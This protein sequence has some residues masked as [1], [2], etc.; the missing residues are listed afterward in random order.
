M[1]KHPEKPG[2]SSGNGTTVSGGAVLLRAIWILSLSIILSLILTIAFSL[3]ID[4]LFGWHYIKDTM[5]FDAVPAGAVVAFVVIAYILAKVMKFAPTWN[6][7][8]RAP[9]VAILLALLVPLLLAGRY[10]G[11][12]NFDLF[13]D[14]YMTAKQADM[15]LNGRLAIPIEG[16]YRALAPPLSPYMTNYQNDFEFWGVYYLPLYALMRAAAEFVLDDGVLSPLLAGVAIIA[17]ASIAGKVWPDSKSRTRLFA[18]I[19]LAST[20]QFFLNAMTTFPFTAH[21]AINMIWLRL[22]LT[23]TLRGH[24]GAM[25]LGFLAIAVHRPHVHILFAAPFLAAL[26]FG[27]QGRKF[28]TAIA[29]ALVYAAGLY[30]WLGWADWSMALATGDLDNIP[31]NPLEF[32]A[33]Q[34]FNI[35]AQTV[36]SQHVD[37]FRWNFMIANF[38]RFSAW[39]NPAVLA[40]AVVAALLA[41]RLSTIEILFGVSVLTS[42]LPYAYLMPNPAVGWGYRFGIPAT[43]PLILFAISGWHAFQRQSSSGAK[44]TLNRFVV[45]A[46][47]GSLFMFSPFRYHQITSET[48]KFAE[49]S[50]EISELDEEIVL[51]DH[52][53]FRHFLIR[54]SIWLDN[55]PLRVAL[56]YVQDEMVETLCAARPRLRIIGPEDFAHLSIENFSVRQSKHSEF[57]KKRI[58]K[59]EAAGCS[60]IRN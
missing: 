44:M 29:F 13:V 1:P 35:L 34:R 38:M 58:E 19:L 18:V 42:I 22:F 37:D 10:L 3:K 48:R 55:R 12:E 40:L 46:T 8:S 9:S 45:I 5:Q 47:V 41:R 36:Q 50:K 31:I 15:F 26:L 7:S 56:Q 24:V 57:T 23:G 20:P 39:L 11:L 6:V 28:G 16:Q 27:L 43:A 21:V 59:I 2:P 51:I 33:L 54:N 17:T 4:G 49:I 60:V 52:F 53:A 32:S 25:L 30:V 14:E